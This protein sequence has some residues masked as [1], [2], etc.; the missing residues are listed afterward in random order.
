VSTETT[1][2]TKRV[3]LRATLDDPIEVVEIRD[4]ITDSDVPEQ[5]EVIQRQLTYFGPKLWVE[6]PDGE[7][8]HLTVAGPNSEALLWERDGMER[9]KAAELAVE[10][11]DELPD[12]KICLQ[13]NEEIRTSQHRTESFLGTCDR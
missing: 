13:C 7:Q 1:T 2:A 10:F 3:F 4:N 5:F 11:G 6:A 9:V 12:A 8:Y